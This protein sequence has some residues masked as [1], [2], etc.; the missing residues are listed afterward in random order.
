[1]V[2][3]LEGVTRDRTS[4]VE[5]YVVNTSTTTLLTVRIGQSGWELVT[6]FVGV[7]SAVV[8]T[9]GVFMKSWQK[10]GGRLPTNV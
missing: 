6:Y 3:I 1:M 9:L 8:V 5:T 2:S 10:L 4:S 7:Y